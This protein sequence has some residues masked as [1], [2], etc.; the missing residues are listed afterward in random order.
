MVSGESVT[1]VEQLSR[2]M[3]YWLAVDSGEDSGWKATTVKRA[4]KDE[5][6]E[7]HSVEVHIIFDEDEVIDY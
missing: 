2:K 3:S 6:E 5:V 1:G 4:K 7:P